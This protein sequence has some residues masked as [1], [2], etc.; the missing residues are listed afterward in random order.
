M[1]PDLITAA[2]LAGTFIVVLMWLLIQH[3]REFTDS[4]EVLQFIVGYFVFGGLAFA[5][6]F[7]ILHFVIKYW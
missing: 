5:T 1:S 2:I 3:K 6:L 7:V 4:S